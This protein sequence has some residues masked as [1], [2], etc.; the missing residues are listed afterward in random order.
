MTEI[1][2]SYLATI[3]GG[4]NWPIKLFQWRSCHVMQSWLPTLA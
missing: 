3:F 4:S 1:P 2:R